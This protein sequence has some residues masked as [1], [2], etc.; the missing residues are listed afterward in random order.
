MVQNG[1]DTLW[2]WAQR[3][4]GLAVLCAVIVLRATHLLEWQDA[5]ALLGI[6]ACLLGIIGMLRD[7]RK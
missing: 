2:K 7:A 5:Q 1:K 4:A 6:A 3:V